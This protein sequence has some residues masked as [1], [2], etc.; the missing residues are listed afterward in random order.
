M[1]ES[2][3]SVNIPGLTDSQ[4]S[5]VLEI[6]SQQK[7]LNAYIFGSRA[8]TNFKPHS[9]IDIAIEMINGDKVSLDLLSKLT[10]AFEESDLPFKVDLV[11]LNSISQNFRD[12]IVSSFVKIK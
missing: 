8:G 11:D 9:D 3:D 4:R 10:F 5:L 1:S 12:R 2:I 6:L 7:T